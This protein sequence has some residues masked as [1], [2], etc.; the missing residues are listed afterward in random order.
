MPAPNARFSGV[1]ATGEIIAFEDDFQT[2]T[3]WTVS[4][5]A[6][7]GQWGRGVPI[8]CD[9]GDPP[10]DADGS[11]ICFLTDNSSANNCNSDVDDGETILTSPNLDASAPGSVISYSRWFN[12]A[13]GASPN[14]DT[15]FVQ[16]SG[17]GGLS[18]VGLEVVGPVSEADGGWYQKQFLVSSY[19]PNSNN[20]R[21]RFIA[22]DTGEGSVVEAAIDGV[23][24]LATEC[25]DDGPTCPGDADGNGTVDFNDLVSLL[26]AWDSTC[27][28]CP[29]DVDGSGT[30]GFDD[31]IGLLSAFGPC[32]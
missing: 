7:D 22:Q 29:E 10:T 27:S 21:I 3:G 1:G 16:V 19:V 26:S 15:M 23:R 30:V 9:R 14:Q 12:N 2:D 28:G 31:L 11:G 4:G 24:L 20:F 8:N 13:V 17:D 5:S 18:W 6:V 32:P 25:I